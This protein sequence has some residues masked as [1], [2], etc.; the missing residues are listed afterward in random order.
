M[1]E[2]I[3]GFVIPQGGDLVQ[4]KNQAPLGL[5]PFKHHFQR[6]ANLQRSAV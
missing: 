3:S 5:G 1:Y 2:G 4:G 6:D